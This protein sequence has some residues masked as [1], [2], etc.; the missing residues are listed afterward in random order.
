M[1]TNPTGSQVRTGIS[2]PKQRPGGHAMKIYLTDSIIIQDIAARA[3][4]VGCQWPDTLG[5]QIP[6]F[7]MSILDL[8]EISIEAMSTLPMST[9]AT[10]MTDRSA[11]DEAKSTACT[12]PHGHDTQSH[13]A[14]TR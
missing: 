3:A 8:V 7:P 10:C 9:Y 4:C 13:R 11:L 2:V 1:T 6:F 14:C 5:L 12:I